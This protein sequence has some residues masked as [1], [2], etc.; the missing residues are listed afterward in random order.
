M[1]AK[2]HTSANQKLRDF[3][4]D[5]MGKV[6]TKDQL[7]AVAAPATEWVRRVRGLRIDEGWPIASHSQDGSLRPGEY[8]PT[9]EPPPGQYEFSRPISGALRAQVLK[10][11]GYTCRMS[12]IGAGERYDDDTARTARL[13]V[14]HIVNKHFGG[15]AVLSNL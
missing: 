2:P 3:L 12:G 6:V 5:H 1:S 11:N 9:A 13:Q 8:M 15:Q 14:G 7:S 4:R 10:R